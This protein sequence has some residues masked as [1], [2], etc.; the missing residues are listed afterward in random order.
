MFDKETNP[1]D[2]DGISLIIVYVS[3]CTIFVVNRYEL[4]SHCYVLYAINI[5]MIPGEILFKEFKPF[6]GV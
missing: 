1:F 3:G 5:H 4:I 6:W 2:S